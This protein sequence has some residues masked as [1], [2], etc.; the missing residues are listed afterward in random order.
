[1]TPR[2][3]ASNALAASCGEKLRMGPED[4]LHQSQE[5]CT[6]LET[7]LANLRAG[8]ERVQ[9]VL[10]A[11]QVGLWHCPLPLMSLNWD[12]RVKEHFQLPPDAQVSIDTFYERL[13]P[14]D[15]DRTRAAIDACIANK[16]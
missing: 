6:T 3:L 11:A 15:R 2:A 16:T 12:A 10:G 14:Q 13:H 8:R 7:A 5:R 4:L 9:A 1:M